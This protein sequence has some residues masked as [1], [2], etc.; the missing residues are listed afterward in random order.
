MRILD[1]M[2]ADS[3]A[4]AANVL[5]ALS[6]AIADHMRQAVDD[7]AGARSSAPATL[8][9]LDGFLDGGSIDQ[10]RDVVGLTSS[11]AVRLVDRLE[12][13]GYVE[14]GRGVDGRSVALRLTA[15]GRTVAAA[16]RRARTAVL[17]GVLAGLADDEQVALAPL[18][19]RLLREVTIERLHA[20]ARGRVSP[21][22]WMCRLCDLAACGRGEGTCPA[23][24]A[25]AEAT[26]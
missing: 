2:D 24:N 10:L 20:R 9:A 11:G 16:V 18:L 7:A 13:D 12:H 21:D 17:D 4:R 26:D 23:E 6:L 15:E 3:R 5:G 8:A 25:V 22:G 1:A 19:E 14:R